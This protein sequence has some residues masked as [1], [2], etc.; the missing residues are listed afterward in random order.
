LLLS[1][2]CDCLGVALDECCSGCPEFSSSTNAGGG[3]RVLAPCAIVV[4]T[5][6]MYSATT[7]T[8]ISSGVSA[9]GG[10][11]GKSA[12]DVLGGAPG[13]DEATDSLLI[14][15]GL[16]ALVARIAFGEYSARPPALGTDAVV[17]LPRRTGVGCGG[18]VPAGEWC[19]LT[20]CCRC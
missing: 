4:A 5:T 15:C 14:G 3:G 7:A 12:C 16:D 18:V 20:R 9:G 11:G 13:P 17:L 8:S 1:A 19:E 2:N 6:S 10:G